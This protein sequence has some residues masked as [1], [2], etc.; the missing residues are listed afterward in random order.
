MSVTL[1]PLV[2]FRID[3]N[4][5]Q[6]DG[7]SLEEHYERF[8]RHQDLNAL[9]A[10]FD[11]SAP[12]LSAF[13]RRLA[14]RR[15]EAEDWVQETFL[16]ALQKPESFP[17][18]GKVMPWLLGI[19]T[20]HARAGRRRASR[21]PDPSRLVERQTPGPSANLTEAEVRAAILSAID[22]LPMAQREAVGRKLLDGRPSMELG[23]EMG[24]R[25]DAVWARVR[26]GLEK[27]RAALPASL[28][29]GLLAWLSPSPSLGAMRVRVLEQTANTSAKKLDRCKRRADGRQAARCWTCLP[30]PC[31]GIRLCVEGMAR[32][33]KW[34]FH[35][36]ASPPLR[37]RGGATERLAC[38][39]F[40]FLRGADSRPAC[41][42]PL[43]C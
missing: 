32:A 24:M 34:S 41:R 35:P 33:F 5:E 43:D 11:A 23:T 30:C 19:L 22:D 25:P 39:P 40:A 3:M 18:G 21:E 29:T 20:N 17:E 4:P 31:R 37:A 42:S 28:A 8:V 36:G 16:T 6:E 1:A 10:L 9:G 15:G 26:R 13:A 7:R 2:S 12:Q 38:D 14:G 27:L